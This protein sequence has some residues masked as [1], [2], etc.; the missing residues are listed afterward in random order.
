MPADVLN[1]PEYILIYALGKYLFKG[2]NKGMRAVSTG[3]VQVS[4]LWT[5]SRYMR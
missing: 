5:L 1:V 2:N 3:V 4:L